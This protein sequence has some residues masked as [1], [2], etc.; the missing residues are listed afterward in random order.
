MYY[1]FIP[2]ER[3]MGKHLGLFLGVFGV[4]SWTFIT[5][6]L[7]MMPKKLGKIIYSNLHKY[8]II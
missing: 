8:I 6:N 7:S 5:M 1:F 4:A 2:Q 3:K